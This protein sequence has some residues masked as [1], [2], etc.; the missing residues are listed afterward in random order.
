MS[1]LLYRYL[2]VEILHD[3]I[4]KQ[5][6]CELVCRLVFET[7]L[8]CAVSSEHACMHAWQVPFAAVLGVM[9]AVNGDGNTTLHQSHS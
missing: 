3:G 2:P 7:H 4:Y 1:T 9:V 5:E 6:C 8:T